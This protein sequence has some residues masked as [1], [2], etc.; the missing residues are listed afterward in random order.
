MKNR[1]VS[2]KEGMF[3]LPQHFQ[4]QEVHIEQQFAASA[5]T[6]RPFNFG[7]SELKIDPSALEDWNFAVDRAAGRT[8]LGFLFGFDT[9]DSKISEFDLDVITIFRGSLNEDVGRF[10]IAVDHSG[11]MRCLKSVGH[12]GD[13]LQ[14]N[15][16]VN[17]FIGAVPLKPL[18]KVKSLNVLH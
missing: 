15:T 12:L 18:P 13:N 4:C 5:R 7:F 6:D 14:A 16:L 17:P 2:W 8:K 1:S 3:L 11:V 9:A 10:D